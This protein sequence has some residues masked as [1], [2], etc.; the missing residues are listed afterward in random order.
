MS[1]NAG[2][3]DRVEERTVESEEALGSAVRDTVDTIRE[4]ASTAVSETKSKVLRSKEAVAN[5]LD[6]RREPLADAL[7][8]TASQ[9]RAK[10][11]DGM[12]AV[13]GASDR[14]SE[15]LQ[16]AATYLRTH[17]TD[18]MM[19]DTKEYVQRHKGAALIA[20]AV[21]GFMIGRKFF[22]NREA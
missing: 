10:A 11:S 19:T 13:C 15:R 1:T 8:R 9:L 7:D 2:G 17:N 3:F 5:Y 20:A 21:I 14:A 22:A 12:T 6:G 4:G 18:A 16:G